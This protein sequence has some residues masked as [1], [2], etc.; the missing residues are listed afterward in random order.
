MKKVIDFFFNKKNNPKETAPAPATKNPLLKGMQA[1][2][3]EENPN[4]E[5][6][7]PLLMFKNG[8]VLV[9]R[10]PETMEEWDE[11][12]KKGGAINFRHTGSNLI[13]W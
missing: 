5:E 6:K 10:N 7:P 4:N 12:I 13:E 9:N 8:L 11:V 1:N 2:Y 3:L